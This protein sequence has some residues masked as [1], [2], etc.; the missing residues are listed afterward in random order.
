[1]RWKTWAV[2]LLLLF[3]ALQLVWLG[4][5][6][7]PEVRDLAWRLASHRTGAAISQED[8]LFRWLQ[9]LAGIIPPQATYVFLDNY[10]SGKEIEARYHLAPRRHMLLPPAVPPDFLFFTLR[11]EKASYLIIREGDQ[12]WES[13]EAVAQSPAF[14]MVPVPG[15]GLLFR[16]DYAR[17]LGRF[18]D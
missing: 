10:E 2:R 3:W 13:K 18:Y 14:Q 11:Q 17:L 15:P 6:F 4:F 8:P 16:V 9:A 5:Y 1:M 7:T 12:T